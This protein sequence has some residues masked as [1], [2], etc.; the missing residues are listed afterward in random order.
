MSYFLAI[1]VPDIEAACA[2]FESLGV[3]FRKN[4]TDG[5]MRNIAFILD[6]DG[7]WVEVLPHGF[8]P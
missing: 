8:E 6:P 1:A 4:L 3:P 2:W 7:Y 5:R